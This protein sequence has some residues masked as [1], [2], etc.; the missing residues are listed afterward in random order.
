MPESCETVL[1][2]KYN[3]HAPRYTSYPTALTFNNEFTRQQFVS[4]VQH[5]LSRS[6]SLYIHIPFC[7]SLCYYCGCNKIVTRHQQKA[8]V[9]LD[10]LEKE[11]EGQAL[12]F[13]R[14]KV[15]QIHLGGGTPSFLNETQ[16]SRLMAMIGKYFKVF[17]D[18]EVSIEIDPRRIQ[19][20]YVDMLKQEGF[21]RISVG[22]QDTNQKVQSAINRPQDT[23][24]VAKLVERAQQLGFNSVN[25]D[26]IYGLPWQDELTFA[27]TLADILLMKPERI[28]LFSYAHMPSRFAAQRKIL[29]HWLPNTELKSRLMRQA[30]QTLTQNGYIF[31]G[32]DHFALPNDE[33][34]KAYRAGDL[35]RNFQGYTTHGDC[36][37]LGLGVSS[38]SAIDNTFSQNK[39]ELMDYY[40]S[41][42][43]GGNALE[44]GVGLST[45]DVLRST[46]IRDLMCN[47]KVNKLDIERQ[48]KLHFDDYFK[49]ELVNLAFLK[50]DGL[51]EVD[52]ATIQVTSRGRLLVRHIASVFD[53]YMQK[54]SL[55]SQ[56]SK[57]I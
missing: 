1:L 5:S 50:Q 8:D 21:N 27:K 24:F 7:H 17:I 13:R 18:A 19:L 45:D 43:A 26:L 4:A 55:T 53:A 10:Y 47:G 49:Q 11:M 36:D 38:I 44:K 29:D 39:K 16:M 15:K 56:L 35:H 12:L 2:K 33:L 46:I 20:D 14:Y 48:F 57:V 51:I 37:L 9:Y 3:T 54:D 42:D 23:E 40:D 25:L 31:I 34:S 41:L 32:M 30:I 6:L 52:A 28:S 22:V